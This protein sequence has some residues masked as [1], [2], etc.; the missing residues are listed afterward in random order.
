MVEGYSQFIN[1]EKYPPHLKKKTK[2]NLLR[3]F[4][5]HF[6]C[7]MHCEGEKTYDKQAD[8]VCGNGFGGRTKYRCSALSK[9]TLPY[10]S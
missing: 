9:W 5:K 3:R 7:P 2:I 10:A 4:R 8:V 6:T 1:K